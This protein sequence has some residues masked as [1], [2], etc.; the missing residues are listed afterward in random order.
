MTDDFIQEMQEEQRRERLMG[1]ARRF[2]VAAVVIVILGLVGGGM[3]YW[4]HHAAIVSQQKASVR[5]FAALRSLEAAS[6]GQDAQSQRK[7]ADSIL[8]DLSAT[9]PEGI[10]TYAR[11]RLADLR[12]QAGD[13]KAALD[14]W[15]KVES[16]H[17]AE[18]S[19]R[20]LALYLSLN[21]QSGEKSDAELRKGYD[22]LI[23]KG[24]SFA[25]LAREGLV[26][27]DLKPNNTADQRKEAKRLLIEIQSSADSSEALR[28]RA[29]LLL[30]TL[31]DVK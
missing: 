11:M 24:G 7:E 20:D 14:L 3:W 15:S 6:A 4:R 16:D 30:K 17:K 12:L 21:A 31:G 27:L 29:G 25:P 23:Q 10:R 26:A 13:K 1:A 18:S 22:S 8:A 28:Q 5:Y 2:G 9:A 19:L